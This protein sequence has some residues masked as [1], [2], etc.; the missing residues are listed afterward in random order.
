VQPGEEIGLVNHL[1]SEKL[2]NVQAKVLINKGHVCDLRRRRQCMHFPMCTVLMIVF[3]LLLSSSYVLEL[4]DKR[5]N[6]PA[7][8]L[9][10]F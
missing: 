3:P 10:Y 8:N 4:Q 1:K 7:E 2:T 5:Q 9:F 6:F